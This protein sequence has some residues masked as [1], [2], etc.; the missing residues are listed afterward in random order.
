MTLK[1]FWGFYFFS[2]F[3]NNKYQV[4]D[5]KGISPDVEKD[6]N[7]DLNWILKESTALYSSIL[8]KSKLKLSPDAKLY[9]RHCVLEGVRVSKVHGE[10]NAV[11]FY[12]YTLIVFF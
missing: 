2:A 10:Y 8:L 6:R 11:H 1:Y 3:Y 5:Y 7:D 12:L 9:S 4:E